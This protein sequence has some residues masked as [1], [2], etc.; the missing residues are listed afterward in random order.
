M[1]HHIFLLLLVFST[2][3]QAQTGMFRGSVRDES[4]DDPIAYCNVFIY[5]IG[6]GA[7]TDDKGFFSIS[8][9]PAGTHK[10]RISCVGYDS[11][12]TSIRIGNNEIV[13]RTFRIRQSVH[14]LSG[15]IVSAERAANL[16]EVRAA[17]QYVAPKQITQLPTIGGIPDLA[18]YLQVLP[19]IVST[20]ASRRPPQPQPAQW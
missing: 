19:G 11:I 4:T 13:S 16:T 10:V 18:Q 3:L 6:K 5:G 12:V 17:V 7:V 1:R 20:G 2:M 9:I 8:R 15:T 14:Q